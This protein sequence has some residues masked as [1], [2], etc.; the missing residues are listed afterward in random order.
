MRQLVVNQLSTDAATSIGP[1]E[2]VARYQVPDDEMAT[3]STL[4]S[5]TVCM[6]IKATGAIATV[7]SPELGETLFG[8]VVLRH[9]DE[10]MGMLLAQGRPGAFVI[11]PE[12]Q[13]HHFTLAGGIE[14]QEDLFVLSGPPRDGDTV[15]PPAVYY[16]VELRNPTDE[17]VP[18]STY[19]VAELRGDTAH[20]VETT[21]DEELGALVAWNAEQPSHVRVFGCSVKPRSY[22]VTLDAGKA[23]ADFS[24]GLL[25]G[26]TGAYDDP[27]GVLHL[28]HRIRPGRHARFSFLLTFSGQGRQAALET[29]RACPGA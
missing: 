16:T 19:A 14:V 29:Y 15:D 18:I 12:H 3:G 20:D 13:E 17:T 8:T 2:Q 27:L 24:P 23:M 7:Y 22:E 6:T 26:E 11:H 4:G 5:P 9:Y 1:S 28:T 10:R 25:S 21:Y